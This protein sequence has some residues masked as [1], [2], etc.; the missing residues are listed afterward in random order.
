M[1]TV[2]AAAISMSSQVFFFSRWHKWAEQTHVRCRRTGSHQCG[3][4]SIDSTIHVVV[5]FGWWCT[6]T[7][8]LHM[9]EEDFH[10]L[11][12]IPSKLTG[13]RG[14]NSRKYERTKWAA[15]RWNINRWNI[16]TST[17]TQNVENYMNK[18][19]LRL[20][21]F[22][23][24]VGACSRPLCYDWNSDSRWE[25]TKY[26]NVTFVLNRLS[27]AI[28]A[29]EIPKTEMDTLPSATGSSIRFV[30]IL[31]V[32]CAVAANICVCSS[33][34]ENRLWSEV[35]IQFANL[36]EKYQIC[37]NMRSYCRMS[38]LVPRLISFFLRCLSI[39]NSI[40]KF[41]ICTNECGAA[42]SSVSIDVE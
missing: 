40:V 18:I 11:R 7:L 42:F 31:L 1:Y 22:A 5:D 3:L 32:L 16:T 19:R 27:C 13:R 38:M 2:Y 23:M 26:L 35:T 21:G 34:H 6:D 20:K 28:R 12:S 14:M 8:W 15:A 10:V 33:K 29:P 30:Y 41:A 39:F 9:K 25:C 37:A 17:E 24:G 4:R 36:H